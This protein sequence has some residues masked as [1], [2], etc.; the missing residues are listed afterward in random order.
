M[1]YLDIIQSDQANKIK[2]SIEKRLSNEVSFEEVKN[3]PKQ[4]GVYFIYDNG[5]LVY[6]G[7]AGELRK[8][9]MQYL[10]EGVGRTFREKLMNEKE[11]KNVE[12]AKNYIKDIC[13]IRYIIEDEH[14]KMEHLAIGLFNPEYND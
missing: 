8:R 11:I 12:D 1:D 6:I 13:K 4:K 2:K 5:T 9:C 3:L 7:Q 14:K 10:Q